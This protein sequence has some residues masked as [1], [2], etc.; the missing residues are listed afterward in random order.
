[1]TEDMSEDLDATFESENI[2]YVL[3]GL[4][5]ETY[6]LSLMNV[7]E[8]I[9]NY[10]VTSIPDA[11]LY[12]EGIIKLREEPI[13]LVSLRARFGLEPKPRDRRSRAV[14]VEFHP[15]PIALLVDEVF[16]VQEI[17][18]DKVREPPSL[19]GADLK[20]FAAGVS[21]LG[22]DKFIV[23]LDI[24]ALLTTSEKIQMA[25][26]SKRLTQAIQAE[27]EQPAGSPG[28][29]PAP[30]TDAIV[31]DETEPPRAAKAKTPRKRPAKNR[32]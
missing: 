4:E 12:C 23:L 27:K 24:H 10:E 22:T 8:I 30:D 21:T 20:R 9:A 3:F 7:Q 6:G 31:H 17:P 15:N 16:N 25:N 18:K 28:E 19:P 1:V 2:R 29:T 14:V 5:S 13:P 11:P 32:A 26:L